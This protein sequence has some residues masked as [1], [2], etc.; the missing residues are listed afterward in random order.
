[1]KLPLDTHT[2][3]WWDS[4][5]DKLPARVQALCFQPENQLVLSLVSV[6]E[7]QIKIQIGKL[8]LGKPLAEA[9]AHQCQTNQIELLPVYYDHVLALDHLPLHHKDPF[10]RLLLA[11]ARVEGMVILSKDPQFRAYAVPVEWE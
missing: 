5:L 9:I 3:M 10:D 8:D 2:F 1:M 11:Q 7:M 6:W 4:D